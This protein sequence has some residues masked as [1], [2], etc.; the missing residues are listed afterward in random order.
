MKFVYLA[1]ISVLGYS[2][3]AQQPVALKTNADNNTL[4]WEV[5][6]NG[7]AAPSYLFG[8]FHMLCKDE[9]K[10][11]DAL[12]Q[13][14]NNSAEVYMELD[15]DDPGVLLGGLSMMSMKGGKKLK[16]I[17]TEDEYKRV[18]IFFK[19]SLKSSLN[20]F[21]GMKPLL[22]TSLVYP[23][24]MPCAAVT[25]VEEQLV[26]LAKQNKKEIRG[27]ETMAFQ[28]SVFDSIP[29]KEQAD[30]LLKTIGSLSKSKRLFDS[31]VKAY[32]SQNMSLLENMLTNDDFGMEG[33][34]DVLVNKRNENWVVQLKDI[35]KKEPVFVATGAGHLPGKDGLI[36]LLLQQGYT[37]RPVENK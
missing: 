3:Y 34:Q 2:S 21:Q 23:K 24:L 11:S 4:L 31:M 30:E 36:A 13:A 37:V 9:I 32:K 18:E 35:M 14:V 25:S 19:D 20:M 5:S 22:L 16:D 8:T 1:L 7:L 10:F 12:K 27:L 6:G 15:M 29:Y 33:S 28:A 17:L 26:K